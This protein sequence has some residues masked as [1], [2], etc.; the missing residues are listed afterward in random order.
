MKASLVEVSLGS[1]AISKKLTASRTLSITLNYSNL[2]F[3][4]DRIV[5]GTLRGEWINGVQLDKWN[6]IE[7]DFKVVLP[8]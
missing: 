5:T 6:A 8:I 1:V 4:F 2:S 3:T 7:V